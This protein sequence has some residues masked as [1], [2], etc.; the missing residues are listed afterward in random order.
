MTYQSDDCG[1][2]W[3]LDEHTPDPIEVYEAHMDDICGTYERI[4]RLG[5][6][7][8]EY[9]RKGRV[10]ID[11]EPDRYADTVDGPAV[12]FIHRKRTYNRKIS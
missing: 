8:Q 5:A 1:F 11:E 9:E 6:A 3:C 4:A 7:R 2:N 12:R 10:S